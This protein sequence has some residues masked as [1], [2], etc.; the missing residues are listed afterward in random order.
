MPPKPNLLDRFSLKQ[1]AIGGGILVALF[2]MMVI[3]ATLIFGWMAY[4]GLTEKRELERANKEKVKAAENSQKALA[5]TLGE[6]PAKKK[7]VDWLRPGTDAILGDAKI[8]ILGG[9]FGA[10]KYAYRNRDGLTFGHT[11]KKTANVRIR[12]TNLSKTKIIEYDTWHWR[13]AFTDPNVIDEHG[14]R[15]DYWIAE[16]LDAPGYGV[17][18][19][20]KINPGESV[21]DTVAFEPA[22]P[23]STEFFVELPGRSVGA[24]FEQSAYFRFSKTFFTPKDSE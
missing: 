20:C 16:S 22:L 6:S 7:D 15:C 5:K 4:T 19:Q 9:D 21:D 12:V 17:S 18:P 3:G 2:L 23:I 24:P 8:A 11:Q 1:I 10:I 13:N 14:N